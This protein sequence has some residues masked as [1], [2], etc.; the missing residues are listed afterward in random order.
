MTVIS[1]ITSLNELIDNLDKF[2]YYLSDRSLDSEFEEVKKL[3]ARGRNF[4]AYKINDSYHFA[5]S[6]FLGYKNNT[7]GK[8]IKNSHKDGRDTDREIAAILNSAAKLDAKLYKEYLNYCELLDITPWNHENRHFWMLDYNI[9]SHILSSVSTEGAMRLRVHLYRE[10]NL[11]I[12][13]EAKRLFKEKNGELYCEICGFNFSKSYGK[14][15]IEYIEA[16]HKIPFASDKEERTIR[17]ED[18]LMVC[19]NCHSV[20]HY[21][22]SPIEIDIL[23]KEFSR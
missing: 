4:V 6:R 19:S 18:F 3:I 11:R 17:V 10:R 2:E 5:P 7:L 23:R 1:F 14:Y 22:Q 9:Q 15:S 21:G 12:V 20:L 16:H 8:H 13:R